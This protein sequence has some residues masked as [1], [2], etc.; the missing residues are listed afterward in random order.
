MCIQP[1]LTNCP[2]GSVGVGV[3]VGVG[4]G[5]INEHGCIPTIDRIIWYG[6]K[7]RKF[8]FSLG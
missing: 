8:A 3:C 7:L 1:E 5:V 6:V 2:I 4:V